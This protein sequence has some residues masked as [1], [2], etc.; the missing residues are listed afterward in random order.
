MNLYK[1][2]FRIFVM[3]CVMLVAYVLYMASL[4]VNDTSVRSPKKWEA[5]RRLIRLL[6]AYADA[7]AALARPPCNTEELLPFIEDSDPRLVLESPR[8]GQPL[9]IQFGIDLKTPGVRQEIPT[10]LAH[11]VL[12]MNGTRGAIILEYG[13][14]PAYVGFFEG[15]MPGDD[16][17]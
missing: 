2:C 8:D 1:V 5:G 7:S 9:W 16:A 11:E 6:N 17:R 3:V 13:E 4:G 15:S 14:R 10:V 12:G